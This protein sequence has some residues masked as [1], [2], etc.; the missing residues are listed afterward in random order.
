MENFRVCARAGSALAALLVATAG[1]AYGQAP[2]ISGTYWATEYHPKI[3]LV[4]GGDLPLTPAG[5]AAYEKNIAGLK[6]GSI[7]DNARKFC[8]PDGIPRV[9]ANPY[10]YEIVYGPPG[11]ITIIYELSHQGRMV[12]GAKPMP[13]HEEPLT[14]R[15]S[16]P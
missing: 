3:Q 15:F 4:G 7:P 12:P 16:K 10:P 2:D 11:Q 13:N 8:V 6:D 14:W 9:L 5:K 1:S